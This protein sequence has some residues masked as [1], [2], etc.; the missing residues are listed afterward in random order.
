MSEKVWLEEVDMKKPVGEVRNVEVNPASAAL[1]AATEAQK[2][3]MWSP[4]MLKLWCI[5]GIGK[6]SRHHRRPS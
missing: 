6:E 3:S 4:G 1:V 2:P 5:L